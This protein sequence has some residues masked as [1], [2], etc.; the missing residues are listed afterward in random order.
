MKQKILEM[1]MDSVGAYVSGEQMSGKLGI[2]RAAVWKHIK[3]LERQGYEIESISGSGYRLS[4]IPDILDYNTIG[5]SLKTQ[6]FGHCIE[7]YETIDSTNS[8]A[9]RLA[10]DGAQEGTIV[11]ADTQ[12]AGRGR[13]DR[14]WISPAKKGL[15]MS[16][17]LRPPISPERAPELTV[18]AALATVRALEDYA[19]LKADIK[20]PN[21][22]VVNGRKICGIL[23]E[24]QA[25][26]DCVH[27]VVMGIGINV[28]MQR[29]DFPAQLQDFATSALIE[30]GKALSR[31]GLLLIL[32]ENLESVY[33]EYLKSDG[34]EPFLGYYKSRSA[35]L[36]RNV[37]VIERESSFEGYAIDIDKDGALMVRKSDGSI[38]KV[39]SAD[40]SVRGEK[41]YV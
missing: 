4:D 20:W 10:L 6:R 21:D 23:A 38:R 17:I 41:G 24:I 35:T 25:E 26:P 37:N 9:K 30:K 28:N 13:M 33:Y 32:L 3:A 16:I 7:I 27:S 29:D 11:I 31:R 15:W 12:S 22:I 36:C 5:F 8:R 1:L 18:L 14:K 40:V 2:S 39:L 34:L 19:E